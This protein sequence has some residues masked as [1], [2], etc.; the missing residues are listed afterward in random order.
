MTAYSRTAGNWTEGAGAGQLIEGAGVTCCWLY[1]IP[2]VER[3]LSSAFGG[4][5]VGGRGN[6]SSTMC[7]SHKCVQTALPSK[8]L[9][10][11]SFFKNWIDSPHSSQIIIIPLK[12]P[13]DSMLALWAGKNVV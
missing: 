6:P 9:F 11:Q 2:I 3:M 13:F 8:G 10:T 4:G 12:R 5:G 7:F 1:W